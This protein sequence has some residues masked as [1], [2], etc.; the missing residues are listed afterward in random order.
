MEKTKTYNKLMKLEDLEREELSKPR[1]LSTIASDIR[2]NW[3]SPYFG[4][5]PYIKALASMRD[6]DE[7]YGDEQARDIVWRFLGNAGTWR[8]EAARAIKAELKAIATV[9]HR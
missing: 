4:A 3:P 8:G 9:G 5:V 6:I 2:A 1:L 7:M